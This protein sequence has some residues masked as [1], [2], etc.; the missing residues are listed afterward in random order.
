MRPVF[1]ADEMRRLDARATGELGL[2]GPVL[3]ERAGRGAAEAI[4]E[5]LGPRRTRARIALV[6][7]KGGNG[8]DG[9]VAARWLK[10]AGARPTV[11]L[12]AQESEVRGDAAQK[13]RA[14]RRAGFRPRP[15]EDEGR[16]AEDLGRA[17]LIVDALLGTGTRG[18]A[19]GLTA[20]LIEL[21][22]AAGRPV[23]ALDIPSGMSADGG[24]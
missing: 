2:P 12:A 4:V 17:D 15:V 14:L 3:M 23:V 1:T 24:P 19:S 18:A 9:F 20:R 16:L 5:F 13:L 22:N 11:W 7:G 10:R 8:G 21:I 6:C